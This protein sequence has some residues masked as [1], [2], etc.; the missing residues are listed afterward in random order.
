MRMPQVLIHE[1][2]G[3][4]AGQLKDLI[5][6]RRW[7]LREV[8]GVPGCLEV[9][10]RGGPAVLVIRLGQDLERE[11]DL[12]EQVAWQHPDTGRVVVGESDHPR[13]AGLAWDLGADAVLFTPPA[14]ERL[15]EVVAALLGA[16]LE[17]D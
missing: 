1:S 2:D 3:R 7:L 14:R 9:L 13:L 12:L 15:P 6:V 17:A 8:R 5:E 10:K 16:P 11:L 4:L